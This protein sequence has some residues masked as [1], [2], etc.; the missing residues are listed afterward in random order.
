MYNEIGQVV[1][2]KRILDRI[3]SKLKVNFIEQAILYNKLLGS[4][5]FKINDFKK[6]LEVLWLAEL[7]SEK[8]DLPIHLLE[9][10]KIEIEILEKQKLWPQVAAKYKE[11]NTLSENLIAIEIRNKVNDL[12]YSNDLN[13]KELEISLIEEERNFAKRLNIYNSKIIHILHNK[14]LFLYSSSY[15]KN[16]I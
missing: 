5:F 6:S 14:L 4:Y 15:I 3:N 10:Y 13:K 8:N 1:D 11:Y 9:I 7:L 2:A 16:I 12:M